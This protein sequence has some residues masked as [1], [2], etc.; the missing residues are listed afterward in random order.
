[1]EDRVLDSQWT[2]SSSLARDAERAGCPN[3]PLGARGGSDS[4]HRLCVEFEASGKLIGA[5]NS[6]AEAYPFLS[7]VDHA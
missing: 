1:M 3:T 6:A 5:S 7:E 4:L 2:S